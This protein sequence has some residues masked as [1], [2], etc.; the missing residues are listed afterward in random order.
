MK[1]IRKDPAGYK[2]TEL[3]VARILAGIIDD[4]AE[5]FLKDFLRRHPRELAQVVNKKQVFMTIPRE[6]FDAIDAIESH[7][8]TYAAPP[9]AVTVSAAAIAHGE[10]WADKNLLHAT[11][12]ANGLYANAKALYLPNDPKMVE[13]AK[14]AMVGEIKNL[15]GFYATGLKRELRTAWE[16]GETM[17]Q[18][19][20]R[21]QDVTGLAKNKAVTIARTE[22]LRA[23]NAASIDRYKRVEVERVEWVSALDDRICEECESLHGK[24]FDIDNIPDLPVH[25]NCRCTVVPLI[26]I[27][28]E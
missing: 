12:S 11:V 19:T 22:T 23:G 15:T 1:P 2:S 25:P 28:E 8:D 3:R 27:K 10:A 9:T 21:I 18:I 7:I 26:T 14:D 20:K 16:K 5:L 24:T 6:E 4:F 17:P 13:M